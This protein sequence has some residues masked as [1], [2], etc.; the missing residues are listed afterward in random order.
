MKS[1]HRPGLPPRS[2]RRPLE[3]GRGDACS[4]S[5]A[6]GA[7]AAQQEECPLLQHAR[8]SHVPGLSRVLRNG[9]ARRL[10]AVAENGGGSEAGA[11]R[12][13][14]QEQY[15]QDGEERRERQNGGPGPNGERDSRRRGPRAETELA[16]L[17][18]R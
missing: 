2:C 12:D 4:P 15:L 7:C 13:E 17:L 14:A 10:F 16:P 18:E 8:V 11:S 5:R 1:E 3:P 9:V 6:G